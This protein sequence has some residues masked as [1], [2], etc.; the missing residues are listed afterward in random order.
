MQDVSF[1]NWFL[2]SDMI[3]EVLTFLSKKKTKFSK[4]EMR[5]RKI[6]I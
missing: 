1:A 2:L 3:S 5:Q 6:T 4:D